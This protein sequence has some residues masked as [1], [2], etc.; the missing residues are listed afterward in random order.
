MRR[1]IARLAKRVSWSQA[2]FGAESNVRLTRRSNSSH[3]ALS[4]IKLIVISMAVSET[5]KRRNYYAQ[6][7]NE[8][9]PGFSNASH[10]N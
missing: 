3:F 6:A 1:R 10:L 5:S 9:S 4:K 8:T 7:S 2:F